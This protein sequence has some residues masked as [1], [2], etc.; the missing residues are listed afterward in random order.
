M[1]FY[2]PNENFFTGAKKLHVAATFSY[3]YCGNAKKGLN[4]YKKL[5]SILRNPANGSI[6]TAEQQVLEQ[7]VAAPS[8]AETILR[9][10]QKETTAARGLPETD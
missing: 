10:I 6:C 2:I 3:F 5:L 7:L 9:Q 8:E 1:P 4:C